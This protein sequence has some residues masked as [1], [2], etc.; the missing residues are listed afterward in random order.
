VDGHE[1]HF[2]QFRNDAWI[3]FRFL[4]HF[5]DERANALLGESTAGFG[6]ETLV[7]REGG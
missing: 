5:P 3:Q 1:T 7:F 4:I 6:K 2:E